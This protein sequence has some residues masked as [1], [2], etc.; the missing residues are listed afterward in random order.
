LEERIDLTI[1]DREVDRIGRNREAVVPLLQ[2]LQERFGYLPEAALQRIAETT[3]ITPATITGI[4]TFFG[5]FRL[6]PR[7]RHMISVCRG[8]ACHVKGADRVTDALRR[9][10]SL[11]KDQDTDSERLFTLQTVA[12]LG[13]C[14]LA[15]AVQIDDVTFGHVTPDKVSSML[16]DFLAIQEEKKRGGSGAG[17][18]LLPG[19]GSGE[20]RIGL[21]SCCQS[22]GS[23]LL[24][25]AL[26]EAVAGMR[27]GVT[28][29]RV[30]CVGICHQTP[31]V[32]V[33]LPEGK[34]FLYARVAPVDAEPIVRRHF[35]AAGFARGLKRALSRGLDRL[36][37]GR[38]SEPVTRFA[39]DPRDEPVAAF[40]TPQKR[41]ATALCGEI[42]PVDLD[43]YVKRDGF[44]ALEQCLKTRDPAEMIDL[45]SSSGL[46]GRGGAGYPTGAKWD[47][48]RQAGDRER[49]VICNGDE[50]DP[51]AFMD[52]MIL[53]SFPFRV[54][55]G[56]ALA[57]FAV[58][59]SRGCFYIRG[60]YTMAVRRVQQAIDR[61]RESGFLGRDLFGTPFSFDLSIMK[62][63]GAFVCGEETAL[64]ASLEGRRGMP[65]LRPPYPSESGFHGKPT[66]VNNVETFA[67]VPAIARNSGSFGSLGTRA[68]P[69]T[70][71]FALAGKVARGGLIEVPMGITIREVVEEI[72]GGV[73]GGKRFKAVQVGGPSG[74]CVPAR[75]ADTTVE[76]ESLISAGAIMGSGGLVVLDEDDCMVDMARYF[77]EFTQNQSCGQCTFCRVGT[78]RMLE[79]LE[80]ICSGRGRQGDC[81]RLASL[82]AAV[83][84]GSLCG[85]GRTAPNPVLSTLAHFRDEFEA[86]IEGRCPAGKCRALIAFSVGEGCIG[87]TLCAQ[88]CP[89]GAIAMAP[90]Q[91][92]TIDAARCIRC[93]TC[94]DRCPVS[95]IGVG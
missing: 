40:M 22:R 70:K 37:T 62:G 60:E 77:L 21:G 12:C 2:A 73:A 85:L 66:L 82:G 39:I 23:G 20:I 92:H 34:S 13:C 27:V 84:Q 42:D 43:A 75:L 65:R 71:V 93:G 87:C 6:L 79:I 61:C 49:Y 80:R 44:A 25:E 63:A 10:L 7:G 32:E 56:M 1:V 4:A 57:A 16:V 54:I 51:G 33:V 29:T 88:G 89:V 30:G 83:K 38:S 48:V 31:L 15:P 45:I 26:E 72:G 28:I 9:H 78:K 68:S 81:E 36:L 52:R 50:G 64:I 14:T 53:E 58:G 74:G 41:V 90:Y 3:R 55:E 24:H 8:T 91:E 35:K 18:R 59:A 46:R 69:G 94:R 86:H 47:K 5:Q 17:D 19:N 95:A 67:L 11:V 76:Y